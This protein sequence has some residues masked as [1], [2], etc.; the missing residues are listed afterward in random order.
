MSKEKLVIDSDLA[1]L[2]PG[3]LE[4]RKKDVSTLRNHLSTKN[5]SEIKLLGHKMKGT[6]GGYGFNTMSQIGLQ[7]EDAAANS[8]EDK[9]ERLIEKLVHHLD[10]IEVSFAPASK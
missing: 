3:F 4:N 8:N 9:I 10:N 6:S 5:F 2:I 7:L 1:D